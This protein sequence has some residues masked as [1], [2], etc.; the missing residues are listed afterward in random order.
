MT[1]GCFRQ[2]A[3]PGWQQTERIQVARIEQL[4]RDLT[5]EQRKLAETRAYLS[6]CLTPPSARNVLFTHTLTGMAEHFENARRLSYPYVAWNHQLF[7][8]KEVLLG[9][10]TDFGL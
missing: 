4:E 7:T 1:K 2:D 5:D 3:I 9:D 6:A 10:L 8:A